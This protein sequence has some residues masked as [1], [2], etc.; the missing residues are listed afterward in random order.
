M[1]KLCYCQRTLPLN[2]IVKSSK[3]NEK[4]LLSTS[5]NWSNVV[6]LPA[7]ACLKA[8]STVPTGTS[9]NA[10]RANW[11]APTLAN[12]SHHNVC[13]HCCCTSYVRHFFRKNIPALIPELVSIRHNCDVQR[14]GIF[15]YGNL[16]TVLHHFLAPV[17]HKMPSPYLPCYTSLFEHSSPL[18]PPRSTL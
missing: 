7:G 3:P 1:R 18:I 14:A 4:G 2:R 5:E 13:A 6:N 17:L 11:L 9:I 8:N 15:F 16:L 12:L 10:N